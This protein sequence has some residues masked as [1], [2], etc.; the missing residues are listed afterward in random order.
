MSADRPTAKGSN[1]PEVKPESPDHEAAGKQMQAGNAPI[2]RKHA[3]GHGKEQETKNDFLVFDLTS[4][5]QEKPDADEGGEDGAFNGHAIQ[6]IS[7]YWITN[8]LN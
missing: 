2:L 7:R 1:P 5:F 8:N 6:K 4:V 3:H